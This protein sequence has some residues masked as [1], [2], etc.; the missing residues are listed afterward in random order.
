MDIVGPFPVTRAQKKFL[1]VAVDYFSKRL[2]SHNGRQFQG[3]EITSWYQ[4]MK[5]AQ[6]F[7]YVAY[8]QENGQTQ[9]VNIIIVQ[10]LKTRLQGKGKDW[11]EELSSVFWSY[12]T[13]PRAP[14][15][16][17]PFNL[18]YGSEAVLLVEIEQSSAQVEYYPD[19]ND[20]SR[21]IELDMVEEKRE[22]GY[23]SNG[24]LPRSGYEII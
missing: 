11:V 14:T 9:V 8:P 2:I 17:I 18:V 3:K 16:E 24:S 10:V 6:S 13:A 5:I 15:Q 22:T 23:D 19:D 1:L 21:A 7:T 4:E 12:R 20:Q